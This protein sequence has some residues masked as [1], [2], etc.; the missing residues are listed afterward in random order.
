MTSDEITLLVPTEDRELALALLDAGIKYETPGSRHGLT[1]D[2][3]EMHAYINL[4]KYLSRM[5]PCCLHQNEQ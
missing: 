4:I 1:F 2:S 3:G 5:R